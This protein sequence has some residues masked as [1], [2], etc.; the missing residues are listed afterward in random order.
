MQG[1]FDSIILSHSPSNISIK[2]GH[3]RVELLVA[4]DEGVF[5]DFPDFPVIIPGLQVI[6]EIVGV[7]CHAR[8]DETLRFLDLVIS[9]NDFIDWLE[10]KKLNEIDVIEI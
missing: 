10:M 3:L 2:R 8:R 7:V 6:L 4:S 1:H 9:S 5:V